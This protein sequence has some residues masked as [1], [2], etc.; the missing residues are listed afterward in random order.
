MKG[1]LDVDNNQMNKNRF[2]RSE[3]SLTGMY[4]GLN[5]YTQW[6]QKERHE[7]VYIH[8]YIVWLADSGCR[9]VQR[10]YGMFG[11]LFVLYVR[12]C[13]GLSSFLIKTH[14]NS[15]VAVITLLMTFS[16]M[17]AMTTTTTTTKTT[18]L[19]PLPALDCP[20][21]SPTCWS[22]YLSVTNPCLA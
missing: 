5:L 6:M 22:I 1:I 21:R 20:P 2:I 10:L 11:A 13:V 8:T 15:Y 7:Y 14:T 3:F 12:M 19:L 9:C 16:V 4:Q 18:M 17:M